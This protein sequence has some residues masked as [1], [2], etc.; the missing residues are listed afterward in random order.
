[1]QLWEN[2]KCGLKQPW[3][4]P[5]ARIQPRMPARLHL[6]PSP[7]EGISQTQEGTGLLSHQGRCAMTRERMLNGL[8]KEKNNKK[9]KTLVPLTCCFYKDLETCPLLCRPCFRASVM[10]LPQGFF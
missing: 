1:M 5:C 8:L 3:A 9:D 6:S 2:K 4:G 10:T 7:G